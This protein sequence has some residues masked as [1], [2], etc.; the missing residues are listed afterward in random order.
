MGHVLLGRL[1]LF[2]SR[3]SVSLVKRCQ[4]ICAPIRCFS[5]CWSQGVWDL[6]KRRERRKGCL[7]PAISFTQHGGP[8]GDERSGV[9][10]KRNM[11]NNQRPSRDASGGGK[12]G[13][14]W[15]RSAWVGYPAS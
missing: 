2:P 1:L 4:L 13:S 11:S 12:L 9:T 10:R 15:L 3:R 6:L 5:G 8:P 14:G 7:F